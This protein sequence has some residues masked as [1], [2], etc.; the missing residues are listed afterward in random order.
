ME[1]K[2]EVIEG[3]TNKLILSSDLSNLTPTEKVVYVKQLC[4]N[5]GL[6]PLT[7]PLKIID[8]YD[9]FRGKQSLVYVTKTAADNLRAKHEITVDILK[10]EQND[11]DGTYTVWVVGKLPNGRSEVNVGVVP[12]V[13]MN[14]KRLSAFSLANAK[15]KCF[16]KAARRLTLSILGLGITVEDELDT[17]EGII[18]LEKQKQ[19]QSQPTDEELNQILQTG[20]AGDEHLA[21]VDQP[22]PDEAGAIQARMAKQKAEEQKQSKASESQLNMIR[23]FS[24][25]NLGREI[26]KEHLDMAGVG[27]PAQLTK[28]Q[29]SYLIVQLISRMREKREK[30][31]QKEAEK[32]KQADELDIIEQQIDGELVAEEP[33]IE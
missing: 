32:E 16:S 19:D 3:I 25:S 33:A 17:I 5:L 20:E 6:D 8:F 31:K 15:M 9:A 28:K 12:L 18:R 7:Q 30:S 23:R 29:A 1:K 21:D 11:D 27:E 10:E 14:G 2:S 22:L 26:I 4:E 24:N 13:D